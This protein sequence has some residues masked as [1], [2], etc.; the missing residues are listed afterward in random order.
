[1]QLWL[2]LHHQVF[3]RNEICCFPLPYISLYAL[4]IV[5]LKLRDRNNH[6]HLVRAVLD[7]GSTSLSITNRL[8]ERLSLVTTNINKSVLGIN[9]VTTQINKMCRVKIMSI[10]DSFSFQ[11]NC[12]VLPYITTKVP[13]REL[14]ICDFEIPSN[15]ALADPT[16]YKPCDIDILIGADLFWDLLGSQRLKLG[17]GMPVL[18]ETRL[19]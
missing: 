8:C 7:S 17:T 6:L 14:N 18:S 19:G 9:N 12:F 10:D 1:M 15:I 11:L 13:S 2:I 4:Y 3:L 5:Y 16:F